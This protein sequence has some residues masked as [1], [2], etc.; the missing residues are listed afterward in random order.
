MHNLGRSKASQL[1][2]LVGFFC[3]V[4]CQAHAVVT[5][6]H[7]LALHK[8]PS[9]AIISIIN[10]MGTTVIATVFSSYCF[11]VYLVDFIKFLLSL[12]E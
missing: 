8:L 9:S 11:G 10:D 1:G 4:G 7:V 5:R 3:R 2:F 12:S 6:I